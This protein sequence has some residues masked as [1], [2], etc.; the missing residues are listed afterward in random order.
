[1]INLLSGYALYYVND[2][3]GKKIAF[4]DPIERSEKIDWVCN[5]FAVPAT[6]SA[7]RR[8]ASVLKRCQ[9]RPHSATC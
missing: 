4:G 2:Y 6:E 7:A 3:C 8:W 1:L 9:Q 5:L